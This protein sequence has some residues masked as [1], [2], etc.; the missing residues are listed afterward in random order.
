MYGV[1]SGVDG[2]Y[3][4]LIGFV[5]YERRCMPTSATVHHVEYDVLP[6]EQEVALHLLVK[7]IR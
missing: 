5:R 1:P 4:R 3:Q 2:F 6:D 7:G